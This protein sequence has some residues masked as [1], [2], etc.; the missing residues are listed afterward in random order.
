M[1]YRHAATSGSY[2][3]RNETCTIQEKLTAAAVIGGISL[4]G[5]VLFFV[6]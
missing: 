6:Y 5:Y 3:R 1:N 2:S 4:V